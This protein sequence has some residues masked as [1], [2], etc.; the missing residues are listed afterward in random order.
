MQ[1]KYKLL[2]RPEFEVLDD[3][4]VSEGTPPERLQRYG[5]ELN[6]TESI[7][8]VEMVNHVGQNV[9]QISS[10]DRRSVEKHTNTVKNLKIGRL[11]SP[12]KQDSSLKVKTQ[13]DFPHTICLPRQP[14]S[15]LNGAAKRKGLTALPRRISRPE[16]VRSNLVSA[17]TPCL[18]PQDIERVKEEHRRSSVDNNSDLA[19]CSECSFQVSES[20]LDSGIGSTPTIRGAARRK[21]SISKPRRILPKSPERVIEITIITL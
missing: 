7:A 15:H 5:I 13:I 3:C 4:R 14:P 18:S 19:G 6:A 10:Y 9:P 8:T 2:E 17:R 21:A 12:I 11:T 16:K 20:S 1:N